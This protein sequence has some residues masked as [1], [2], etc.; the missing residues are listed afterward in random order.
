M[1]WN[2]LQNAVATACTDLRTML[3]TQIV[4]GLLMESIHTLETSVMLEP[5]TL[6]AWDKAE[7]T[8]YEVLQVWRI[9]SDLNW[10]N[11]NMDVANRIRRAEL[12]VASTSFYVF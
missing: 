2:N 7:E 1:N 12:L 4:S 3:N 11:G 10:E 9:F 8:I 6:E 5:P